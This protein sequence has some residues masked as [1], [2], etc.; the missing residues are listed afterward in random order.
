MLA[1]EPMHARKLAAMAE[2]ADSAKPGNSSTN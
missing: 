1:D 2:L